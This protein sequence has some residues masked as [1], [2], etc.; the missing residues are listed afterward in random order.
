MPGAKGLDSL[1]QQVSLVLNKVCKVSQAA[2]WNGAK[3]NVEAALDQFGADEA[4]PLAEVSNFPSASKKNL[5]LHAVSINIEHVGMTSGKYLWV[6]S[7]TVKLKT[8]CQ[9]PFQIRQQSLIYILL[10]PSC[11]LS[12]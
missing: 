1:P 8:Y 7:E 12:A 11:T 9:T 4:F 6:G 2:Q 5:L 10:N 3:L